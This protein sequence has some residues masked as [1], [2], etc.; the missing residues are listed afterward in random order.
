MKY[1]VERVVFDW[2][3]TISNDI[4]PV[5]ETNRRIL[6]R[7]NLP[8]KTFEEWKSQIQ[9]TALDFLAINGIQISDADDFA[10]FFEE[11]YHAVVNDGTK[12]EIY[13]EARCIIKCLK[14]MKKRIAVISAHPTSAILREMREYGL[15]GLQ[16]P[17]IGGVKD[18]SEKLKMLQGYKEMPSVYVG[19]MA[20]DIRAAKAAGTYSFAIT[21]GYHPR[22]LLEAEEP[23][24]LIDSLSEIPELI[25]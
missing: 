17:V 12:P 15:E 11:T 4:M 5:Y 16:V 14:G 2:S 24:E 10:G 18:K 19:D 9:P 20:S 1:P 13:P 3:G 8:A 6:Q 25:K 7:F 22:R 21:G 23:D